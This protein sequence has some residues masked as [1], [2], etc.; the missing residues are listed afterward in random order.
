MFV[1]DYIEKSKRARVGIPKNKKVYFVDPFLFWLS[2]FKSRKIT[3]VTLADIDEK[4]AGMLAELSAYENMKQY[5]DL[6]TGENDFDGRRYIYFEK[7]R[8]GETD[9]VVNFGKDAYRL[10]CKFGKLK[11]E[12]KGVI[13]LT[14]DELDYNKIPL[15]IFL[16]FP[17]DSIKLIVRQHS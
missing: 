11:K 1:V 4:T 7:E 3:S 13:Y 8:S 15:S 16:L 14:K 10:E 17:E 9:F 6:K 5:I 12:K 2:F